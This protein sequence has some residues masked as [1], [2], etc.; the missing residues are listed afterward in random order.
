[1]DRR[2]R[3][4]ARAAREELRDLPHPLVD[5]L[6]VA[7]AGSD[8]AM[9]DEVCRQLLDRLDDL[10]PSVGLGRLEAVLYPDDPPQAAVEPRVH[11]DVCVSCVLTPQ[12]DA[13]VAA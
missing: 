5:R 12:P 10:E 4:A 9:L 3:R 8:D 11:P 2:L 7:L 1:M 13:T 6:V